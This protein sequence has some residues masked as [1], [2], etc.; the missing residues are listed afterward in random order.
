M[1]SRRG[2]RTQREP[3]VSPVRKTRS[4]VLAPLSL[5]VRR[6]WRVTAPPAISFELGR[7]F[8]CAL[9]SA[10]GRRGRDAFD[11]LLHSETFQLEHPCLSPLPSAAILDPREAAFRRPAR[12]SL[13]YR[14]LRLVLVHAKRPLFALPL[15]R[16]GDLRSG[17][18]AARATRCERGWRES[19]FTTRPPLR[20]PS[21]RCARAFSSLG[22]DR[23][24][25]L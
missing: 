9:G 3:D 4:L 18:R 16:S 25:R 13:S 10:Q 15:R 7:A 1:R 23:S 11:R 6:R 8:P 22:R 14:A 24:D 19:R 2:L 12:G 21:E 5:E 17:H 20:R